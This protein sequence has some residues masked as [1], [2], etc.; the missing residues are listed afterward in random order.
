[1]AS[2]ITFQGALAHIGR[3]GAGWVA[4]WWRVVHLGALLLVLALS[5]ASYTADNR[6]ALLRHLYVGTAPTL[7]WFSV[8]STLISL[9]LI[10]IVLVTALSYGLSQYALEMVVR[11]LVLELIPLTA[12]LFAA[13]RCTIP[14]AAEIAT[15]PA[16][17][18]LLRGEVLPRVAAG[19]F[20]ALMLAAV[21]CVVTLVVAYLSVYG[22][23]TSGFAAYTHTVG[24]V[25]DAGVSLVF[26]L[27]ILLLGMAVALV[28]VAVVLDQAARGRSRT[29]AEL[30]GLVRMFL[31]ILLIEAASLVGNYY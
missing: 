25:F 19:V 16:S 27:K 15:L 9:V 29:S 24:H 12:A 3:L 13:L 30:Q 22:L 14:N 2:T 26:G 20:C 10:R 1:M 5:P 6:R 11:V 7:L 31:L 23:S 18:Q 8:I 21:S 17:E 28:P 4:G